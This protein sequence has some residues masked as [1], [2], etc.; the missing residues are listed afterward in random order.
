MLV[1]APG[2]F[3]AFIISGSGNPPLLEWSLGS[4][5]QGSMTAPLPQSPGPQRLELR[6]DPD[7]FELEAVVG[8]GRDQRRVAEKLS[9]GK[10]WKDLFGD[11]PRIAL[12][13]LEGTCAFR[14][15]TWEGKDAKPPMISPAPPPLPPQQPLP[16]VARAPTPT[17][18]TKAPPKKP[19]PP[20]PPPKK[21]APKKR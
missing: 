9:L 2:R 19:A 14:D 5:R 20:P 3:V 15:L 18:V 10:G 12:G 6:I 1:G 21:P 11:G 16:E 8:K 4:G 17:P 7:T 13:C